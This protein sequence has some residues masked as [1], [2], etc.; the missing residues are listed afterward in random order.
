MQLRRRRG[1][2]AKLRLIRAGA[3]I[4]L[5]VSGRLSNRVSA[6]A[7]PRD[8]PRPELLVRVT[9]DGRHPVYL[10]STAHLPAAPEEFDGEIRGAFVVGEGVYRVE[11]MVV[12][13]PNRVCSGRADPGKAARQRKRTKAPTPALTVE[14]LPVS[15]RNV[16]ACNA[17]GRSRD[18][19]PSCSAGFNGSRQVISRRCRHAPGLLVRD[20]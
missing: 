3:D 15:E 5:A 2:A 19:L 12:E 13:E 18:D 20:T 8:A 4:R 6:M 14:A 11:T 7:V 1:F 10:G 16:S 17:A 9:P